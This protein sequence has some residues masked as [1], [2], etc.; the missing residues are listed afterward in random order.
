MNELMTRKVSMRKKSEKFVFDERDGIMVHK[1]E[2][3]LDGHN[4]E[5]NSDEYGYHIRVD[6]DSK[7]TA[8]NL[9]EGGLSAFLIRFA[10]MLRGR[11]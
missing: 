6:H 3:D 2:W 4:I 10:R 7:Q 11:K 5:V 8:V 1:T 9:D